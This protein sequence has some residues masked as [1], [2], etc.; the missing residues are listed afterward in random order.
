MYFRTIDFFTLS[1]QLGLLI[2]PVTVVGWE[3]E[4]EIIGGN[5]NYYEVRSNINRPQLS[6]F[7]LKLNFTK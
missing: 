3:K 5:Y 2:L 4:N 1:Q 6:I 7:L